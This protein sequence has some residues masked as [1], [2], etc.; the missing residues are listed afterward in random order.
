[1]QAHPHASRHTHMF[2]DQLLVNS[3]NENY[4]LTFPLT[5]RSKVKYSSIGCPEDTLTSSESTEF[6]VPCQYPR[7]PE[8][9]FEARYLEGDGIKN[10]SIAPHDSQMTTS[11][12]VRA[13]DWGTT[14]HRHDG[15]SHSHQTREN[16]RN[17]LIRM[18]DPRGFEP[19]AS[20]FGG[21]R[22]IQ[23]SYGCLAQV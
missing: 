1:M 5:F 20:A 23:L 3:C 14:W 2:A 12:L 10:R 4:P 21:Q 13:F 16:H 19:L 8:S 17:S 9:K 15:D 18:A 22:S 6:A 11:M 7:S